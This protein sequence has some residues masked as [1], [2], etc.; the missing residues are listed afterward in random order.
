M[1]DLIT[2]ENMVVGAALLDGSTAKELLS[3]LRPE[4]FTVEANRLLLEA[5]ARLDADGQEIDAAKAANLSGV[6]RRYLYELMEI[7]PV[8]TD[9]TGHVAEIRRSAMRRSIRAVMEQANAEILA[10]ADPAEIIDTAV[11]NLQRAAQSAA[12]MLAAGEDMALEFWERLDGSGFAVQTGIGALD[13]LLGGGMLK[14][15][16][17]VMAA[18]PGCGKTALALQIAD[19]VARDGAVLFVSLEMDSVQLT[20]RRVSR[21][22]R[23]PATRLLLGG[24]T[25][26]E[27]GEAARCGRRLVN[28]PLYLNRTLRCGV[29][30]IRAMARQ[31]KELRLI[32]IDYLGLIRPN[33]RLKS[34]YEQITEISGELKI[35]ARTFGVPVLCLAQLNRAVEARADKRPIL[36]DLRDSG[37]IEQDA[38]AVL[39]LH[40]PDMYD[41]EEKTSMVQV[42]VTVAKNR[43]AGT[44]SI[45]MLMHLES[46]AFSEI[47][48]RYGG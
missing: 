15:G 47:E 24:A 9:I 3:M 37:A 40:R 2:S 33:L 13:R 18:R 1:A 36:A 5:F 22:C 30:E 4:D 12:P 6:D 34:R 8:R 46:G 7:A 27:K 25:A 44:G 45:H 42:D 21:I 17:Y 48:N 31:V 29:S 39:F 20:A 23:I 41:G 10:N 32:V 43:H 28:V 35:L 16:L 26:E 38:D 14:S 19:K 11:Q